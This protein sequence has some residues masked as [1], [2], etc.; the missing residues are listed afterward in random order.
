M[1][2][3]LYGWQQMIGHEWAVEMLSAAIRHE[4]VGHAYLI[5][6]PAQVGKTTLARLFA[7]ALNCTETSLEQRPCGVCRSCGLIAKDHHPDVRL[8]LGEASGRGRVTLKID[9]MRELQQSLS[10]TATEARYKIAIIKQFDQ[11]TIG[12]ANAFLKTLEEP[13]RNVI[14]IL[15]AAD[16]DTLLP[17][18][19]SRCRTI[20]LR[21]LPQPLIKTALENRWQVPPE[22]AEKLA[23]L[24]SGRLGWAVTAA[25]NPAPLNERETHIVALHTALQGNR[26]HR[27][28]QADKLANDVERLPDLLR[29]WLSWWRDLVLLSWGNQPLA[30][31]TNI[32]EQVTLTRLLTHWTPEQIFSCLKQTHTALWQLERNANTR[33]VVENLL[34]IYPLPQS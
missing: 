21:P 26:A 12:A 13:P 8:V 9:Q 34:L 20:P 18:I 14:L 6:G 27:F 11:A 1:K 24:A 7:Q 19:R 28:I 10:L 25:A 23:H 17:T 22:Q 30:Q 29:T 15:T 32:D 16:S 4:R 5:T 2:D 31:L 33:L 3:E